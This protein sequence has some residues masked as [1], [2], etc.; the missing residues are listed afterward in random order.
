MLDN[1]NKVQFGIGLLVVFAAAGLLL[2][3]V[4]E[5]GA[6]AGFGF[7]GSSSSLHRAG[8]AIRTEQSLKPRA[9]HTA[10]AWVPRAGDRSRRLGGLRRSFVAAGSL[11]R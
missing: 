9:V 4:L 10:H 3:N 2:A 11:R 7:P 8:T 1:V 5:S 6:A